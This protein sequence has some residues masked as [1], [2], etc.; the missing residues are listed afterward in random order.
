[1]YYSFIYL[2][3]IIYFTYSILYKMSINSN[4]FKTGKLKNDYP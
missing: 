1:M 2:V 3:F 4:L